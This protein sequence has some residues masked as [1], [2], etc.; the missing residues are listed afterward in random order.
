VPRGVWIDVVLWVGIGALILWGFGRET[1]ALAFLTLGCGFPWHFDWT[2]GAFARTPWLFF[3]VA[4]VCLLKKERPFAGGFSLAMAGL[5]RVFP[6]VFL[7]GLLIG[8]IAAIYRRRN[9][10]DSLRILAG[11]GLAAVLAIGL[12]LVT[13][14]SG[15]WTAFGGN[16]AKHAGTPT[17]NLMGLPTIVGFDPDSSQSEILG[18]DIE[19]LERWRTARIETLN[20]RRVV[21]WTLAGLA[22]GLCAWSAFRRD[23]PPWEWIVGA[24]LLAVTLGQLNSYYYVFLILLAP[25]IA[26]RPLRIALLIACLGASQIIGLGGF[27]TD[28]RFLWLSI[29]FVALPAVLWIARIREHEN[30]RKPL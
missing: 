25:W 15:S 11:A 27:E 20:E 5:L 17:G 3:L 21:S 28:E 23:W 26:Q 8:A 29:V 4:G 30:T 7:G 24:S 13:V 9:T 6:F 18:G 19:S 10:R 2:G 12:T 1:L 22:I 16:L 14:G